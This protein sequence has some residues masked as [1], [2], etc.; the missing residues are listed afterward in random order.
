MSLG[1][2]MRLFGGVVCTLLLAVVAVAYA[3]GSPEV[4]IFGGQGHREFLGCLN[5]SEMSP[6]SV[7]NDMSQ[8]GWGNGF[9]TWNPFG[10]Y[11]NPY[12][13]ESACNEYAN[14][15]PVLV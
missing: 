6:N 8:Y 3:Q 15:P 10:P 5:C 2:A 9:A 13:S 7:W 11:K 1:G 4:L 12:G 14:D